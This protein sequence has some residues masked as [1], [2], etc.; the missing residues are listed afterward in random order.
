MKFNDKHRRYI[1]KHYQTMTQAEIAGACGVR[2]PWVSKLCR[3]LGVTCT[4]AKGCQ[5]E[6]L[7]KAGNNKR[8]INELAALLNCG[9]SQ[10]RKL[11][12][13]AGI[14]WSGGYKKRGIKERRREIANDEADD[15][16]DPPRQVIVRSPAV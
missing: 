9:A 8:T 10:A 11:C 15:P 7:R 2:A 5:I 6:V 16:E 12:G 1:L 14:A 3:E 13:S 4:T